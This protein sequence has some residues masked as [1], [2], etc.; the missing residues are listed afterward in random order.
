MAGNDHGYGTL[1]STDID[2]VV[3]LIQLAFGVSDTDNT[4]GWMERLGHGNIRVYRERGRPVGA[5][6]LIP[7]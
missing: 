5:A 7:M 3:R 1:Q 2:A 4:L 6:A